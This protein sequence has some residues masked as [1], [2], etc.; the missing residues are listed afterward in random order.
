M[1]PVPSF[2]HA[3]YF[4]ELV[5]GLSFIGM[6]HVVLL[7]GII[8][9]FDILPVL[10]TGGIIL[11]WAGISLFQGEYDLAIQLLI[12]YLTITVIRNLIEPKLVGTQLGM[13][14]VMMLISM[15][16]GVYVFGVSGLYVGPILFSLR[17]F[18]RD[19]H[20]KCWERECCCD[21]RL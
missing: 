12:L 3:D 10:G 19:N 18:T 14:P 13:H 4:S 7:A 9:V 16:A 15:Y 2:D 5:V 21:R 1:Y 6:E 8:A 20:F 11:P 17:Q